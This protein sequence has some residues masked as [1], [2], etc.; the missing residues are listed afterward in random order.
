MATV[1]KAKTVPVPKTTY[2]L[3]EAVALV[4]GKYES[5]AE[6]ARQ[7]GIGKAYLSRLMSGIKANPGDDV[8]EKMG[9]RKHATVEYSIAR[10][11][12]G[13]PA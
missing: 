4:V 9:I 8:L 5:Q 12:T 3:H 11:R 7:I 6:A 10:Q 1:K 2:A 13:Q